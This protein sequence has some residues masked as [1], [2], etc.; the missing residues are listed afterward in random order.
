MTRLHYHTVGSR[1]IDHICKSTH[2]RAFNVAYNNTLSQTL[3]ILVNRRTITFKLKKQRATGKMRQNWVCRRERKGY[4]V[5]NGKRTPLQNITWHGCLSPLLLT[6]SLS[7]FFP[8]YTYTWTMSECSG[9]S[10]TKFSV[11]I[12]GEER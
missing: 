5:L 3:T 6:L 7:P 1:N 2:A 8:S 4:I 11:L 10:D 9:K 12:L